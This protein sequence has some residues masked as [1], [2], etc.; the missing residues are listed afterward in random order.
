MG[1]VSAVSVTSGSDASRHS[2]Q[3]KPVVL[4]LRPFVRLNTFIG[5][6]WTLFIP[7]AN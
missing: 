1:S 6:F 3:G 2:A 4:P 5:D 7:R